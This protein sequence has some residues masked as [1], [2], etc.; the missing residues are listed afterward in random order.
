MSFYI[1]LVH[2]H[3]VIRWVITFLLVYS[4]IVSFVKWRTN[5][6]MGPTN[7]LMASFTVHFSHLQLLLGLVLYVISP[8]VMF[9][10]AAM[11]SSMIRFFTLDHVVMMLI[12]I[13]CLTVG[14][15][16][17]KR[18]KDP[19][20]Q[21]KRIFVWYTVGLILILAAIPWPFRMLGSGW[22]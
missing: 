16:K 20:L 13:T 10:K 2:S 11:A 6:T 7:L 3:S 22:M 17:A 19:Q 8:K 9:D 4:I 5:S 18:T 1:Y 15:I 14:H 12:A 21:A